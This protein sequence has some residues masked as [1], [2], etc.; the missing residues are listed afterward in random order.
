MEVRSDALVHI[1]GLKTTHEDTYV[2]IPHQGVA[3][4]DVGC[5]TINVICDEHMCLY[6]SPITLQRK[7]CQCY[8]TASER[9]NLTYLTEGKHARLFGCL[10]YYKLTRLQRL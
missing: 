3:L 10:P 2:I 9:P 4:A 7:T 1:F 8:R 6:Y 5:K